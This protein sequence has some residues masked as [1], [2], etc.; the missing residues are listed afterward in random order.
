MMNSEKM[1]PAH[2]CVQRESSMILR[3][4]KEILIHTLWS[5][6]SRR[7]RPMS[8]L[9]IL[10]VRCTRPR[11]SLKMQPTH[12]PNESTGHAKKMRGNLGEKL[13]GN[14]EIAVK[15]AVGVWVHRTVDSRLK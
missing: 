8:S 15:R 7:A 3:T 4:H 13:H 10:V 11:C 5:L 2:T 6:S 9:L 14:Q 12:F 1:L